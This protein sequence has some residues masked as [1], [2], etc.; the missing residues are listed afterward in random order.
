MIPEV[1]LPRFLNP[2]KIRSHEGQ[3]SLNLHFGRQLSVE[4]TERTYIAWG[5]LA[6]GLATGSTAGPVIM[7][8][9]RRSATHHRKS[10]VAS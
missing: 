3:E 4:D 2:N 1:L 7:A 10:G 9:H 6:E 8:C 5:F